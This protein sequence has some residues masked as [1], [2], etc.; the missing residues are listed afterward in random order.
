MTWSLI[1]GSG[2]TGGWET[3]RRPSRGGGD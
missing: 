3:R 2:V 1:K